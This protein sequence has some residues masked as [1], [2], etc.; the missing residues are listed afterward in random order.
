MILQCSVIRCQVFKNELTL[1]Q[2]S[3]LSTG[4][5]T[6]KQVFRCFYKPWVPPCHPYLVALYGFFFI[7]AG[8]PCSDLLGGVVHF[9]IKLIMNINLKITIS[10]LD[11]QIS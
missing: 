11:I 6:F 9:F 8:E 7:G 3:L 2:A 4:F 1:V 5:L 10:L